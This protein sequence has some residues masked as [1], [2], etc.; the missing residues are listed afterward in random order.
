M[1]N[2]THHGSRDARRTD[3][4]Q[5]SDKRRFRDAREA[6]ASLHHLQNLA[7]ALDERGIGHHIRVVRKY[8]CDACH[9]WHLTSW[10]SPAGPAPHIDLLIVSLAS[11]TGLGS[12]AA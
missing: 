11:S 1:K 9:G 12:A 2:T 10:E 8:R 5:V 4:C 6:T 7:R 3:Y